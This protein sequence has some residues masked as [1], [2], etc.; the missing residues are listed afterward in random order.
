MMKQQ[1]GSS[2]RRFSLRKNGKGF[3]LIEL[4]VVIA[5][6]ALLAAAVLFSISNA[7]KSSRNAGRLKIIEEYV[8]ALELVNANLGRYTATTWVCLGDYPTD[9]QCFTGGTAYSDSATLMSELSTYI[10]NPPGNVVRGSTQFYEGFIYQAPSI[11][12]GTTYGY[13][14][15]YF[16]EGT[17]RKCFRGQA[18]INNNYNNDGVTY[19]RY[20]HQ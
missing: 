12:S 17:S 9:N 8:K 16:L 11:V 6:I 7:G 20:L 19:C 4:M 1:D 13:E 18:A 3:T 10:A 2:Q 14:I 15:R 5:I